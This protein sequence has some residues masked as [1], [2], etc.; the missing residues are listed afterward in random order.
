LFDFTEPTP[1][2]ALLPDF[3]SSC[4]VQQI[5]LPVPTATD[6]CGGAVTVT[7]DAVFPITASTLI[8]WTYTDANGNSAAQ[9]QDIYIND[10]TEPTPDVVIL[11]DFFSSCAV[12]Q[13]DLPVPTA[14]DNCSGLVTV[15]TDAVFPITASTL[16]TW[17]YTDASGNGA[18]QLQDVYINDFTEPTP[19]IAI[20]S[21][22][23]SSC[24]VQ[25]IDLP[26]P[27][28]TDNCGGVVTVTSDVVFPITV[29]T[30][31]TWTYTDDSG[32]SASQLQD[33][34]INDFTAP[35]P[36]LAILPDVVS[37]CAVQQIDVPTPTA[38]DNC[39]GLVTVTSDAVF[40]ITAST[41]ITW[42]YTDASGNT[43]AQLQDIIITDL[44]APVAD[45]ATLADVISQCAIVEADL[46]GPT[47]TDNCSGVVTVTNDG[48]FP[49]TASTTLTWTYT[50]GNGNATTQGQEI[51]I[52]DTTAPTANIAILTDITA[53]CEVLAIDVVE[54][55]A[56]D[57]CSGLVTVTSDAV[58][59]ITSST[60]I[61]WTYTDASGNDTEQTQQVIIND[62]TAPVA[63]VT[64][65]T[66]ITA[67]CEV[68]AIDVNQPTATDNCVG[69]VTVT[70]DA[71][72]PIT[73]STTITWTYT[74]ASGNN[75]IQT[76]QVV[77]N[78]TTAPVADVA[79]LADITSPCEVLAID[80]T[81]PTASDN[82]GGLVTVTSDAVF[83]ITSS[84][85]ITWTYTDTNGN[86]ASLVTVTA[87]PQLSV[88]VG[89]GRSLARTSQDA[90]M[91]AST[92][93][94]GVGAVVS[95][96]I[97]SC[98]CVLLLPLV[99]VYV[100][101]MAVDDVIGKTASLVTV[102]IPEQLSV[103]VGASTSISRTSHCA[104]I[105]DKT[106]ASGVGAVVSFTITCCACVSAFP[107]P[108]VYVHV[109]FVDDV[110]GNTASLVT[111]TM[112]PQL[113]VAEGISTSFS[114]TSHC[115]MISASKAKSGT[116]AL[117]SLMMTS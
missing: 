60:T 114:S 51:I 95:L 85:T 25:Q 65:L 43:E 112:P 50:D 64:V 113:S 5:D 17:T 32:N 38:T 58:F 116:G 79:F 88:A 102:T 111:I 94:S 40:P 98:V 9:L 76:Q 54:P 83:P 53:Q 28:A 3:F 16:I 106:I 18:S 68:L 23:F 24:A 11:P 103:A 13:I 72:F 101:V 70:N 29:S 59:P 75:A 93:A 42:T 39:G 91:S 87:P 71:V 8:T 20:L 35:T 47:A 99:S 56:T 80:V 108:S 78:D 82:C 36:D 117:I 30:L 107:L 90:E 46:V 77:I 92:A 115:A 109:M 100:H 110:I 67:Q 22:F 37:S 96:T 55:T 61:T 81:E 66:D 105:S 41:L 49:I 86:T 2:V 74:D 34:Y 10:F 21:D 45:V 31:I 63:D 62:T 7:S 6:N 1:D 15:T 14:T 27:T 26:V 89:T 57:N 48:I 33:V 73:A 12:Q 104:M 84:T 4:A 69:I 44:I 52:N 97:T 19:D